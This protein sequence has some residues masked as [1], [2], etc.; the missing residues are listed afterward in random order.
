MKQSQIKAI[1]D[2]LNKGYSK[3]EVA[4][5][6][7]ISRT[8][9]YKILELFP[10]GVVTNK[11][12]L[13]KYIEKFE[14]SP[15]VQEFAK[16]VKRLKNWKSY[17][18]FFKKAWIILGKKDPLSWTIEDFRT[19]YNHEKFRDPETGKMRFSDAVRMRKIMAF[20]GQQTGDTTLITAITRGLG[21]FQTRGL[22]RRPKKLEWYL[23]DTEI[24]YLLKHLETPDS[25]FLTFMGLITGARLS[26]L[27][28]VKPQ[29]ISLRKQIIYIYEPKVN[30][31]VDKAVPKEAL[32]LFLNYIQFYGIPT[33]KPLFPKS[34]AYYRTKIKEIANSL[35]FD[36]TVTPHIL[37]HTCVTQMSMHN[38]SL[39]VISK[40]VGTDAGT[41]QKFYLGNVDAKL[42]YEILG[43][44]YEVKETFKEWVIKLAKW[45]KE[46]WDK[47]KAKGLVWVNGFGKSKAKSKSGVDKRKMK[48]IN[49][50]AV[51][52]MVKNPKTPQHLRKFWLKVLKYKKEGLSDVMALKKAKKTPN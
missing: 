28:L 32:E 16:S 39:E 37:K 8:T 20:I 29:D 26:A 47:L 33:N 52:K 31:L 25:L 43:E 42:R 35:G 23:N 49:W 18:S 27:V 13:P 50:D 51:K 41:L 9:L 4:K 11:R 34:K 36:K 7:K 48:K 2:M 6:F 5:H 24:E 10:K 19:L 30:M 44:K 17:L 14:D 21:E 45:T 40:H 1:F 12:A 3:S 22:K 15:V 38:I 46:A